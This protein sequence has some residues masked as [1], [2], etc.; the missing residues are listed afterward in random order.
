MT[1]FELL[2]EKV[3]YKKL[4][5]ANWG[6]LIAIHQYV[7]FGFPSTEYHSEIKL[8]IVLL[9]TAVMILATY[10]QNKVYQFL[11]NSAPPEKP[12]FLVGVS[13]LLVFSACTPIGMSLSYPLSVKIGVLYAIFFVLTVI[14]TWL[15]LTERELQSAIKDMTRFSE[16][17]G[18]ENVKFENYH[19]IIRTQLGFFRSV[20][21]IVYMAQI[22]GLYLL[23]NEIDVSMNMV[24]CFP[25]NEHKE[26]QKRLVNS[27]LKANHPQLLLIQ[28][29]MAEPNFLQSIRADKENYNKLE[30]IYS[31]INNDLKGI[32]RFYEENEEISQDIKVKQLFEWL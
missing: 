23:L 4:S 15:L 21:A 8:S 2:K 6:L 26:E 27:V 3:S 16:V 22:G 10:A 17:P 12:D 24:D 13:R 28:D 14:S 20:E 18:M 7:I 1:K 5:I 25:D 31:T 30:S 19:N 11:I 32:V 29:L 9:T